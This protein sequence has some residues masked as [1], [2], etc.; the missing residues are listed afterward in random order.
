MRSVARFLRRHL[1]FFYE[2]SCLPSTKLV[3]YLLRSQLSAVYEAS[4]R[5]SMR[6]VICHP[7][8]LWFAFYQSS[9]LSS[10]R[11]TICPLKGQ[12][13]VKIFFNVTACLAL[14]KA[15]STFFFSPTTYLTL[16]L[17]LKTKHVMNI[18]Y[19]R[20]SCTI[21]FIFGLSVF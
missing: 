5:P 18:S 3:D 7:C 10:M 8:G 2:V 4:F 6:S 16:N 15:T 12:N 11:T 13:V 19:F 9:S 20:T 1:P 21:I 17:Q 14:P